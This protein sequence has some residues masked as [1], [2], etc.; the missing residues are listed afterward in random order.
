[1]RSITKVILYHH[2]FSSKL[3]YFIIGPAYNNTYALVPRGLQATH[4]YQLVI[5]F[6]SLQEFF[7]KLC[8]LRCHKIAKCRVANGELNGLNQIFTN[9]KNCGKRFGALLFYLKWFSFLQ[10][11]DF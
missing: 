1:M 5:A 8:L 3:S 11:T 6:L 4:C 9:K 2:Y 7:E 10:Y